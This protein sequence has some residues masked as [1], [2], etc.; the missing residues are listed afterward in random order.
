MRGRVKMTVSVRQARHILDVFRGGDV[1]KDPAATEAIVRS[2]Q[3]AIAYGE[4][5]KSSRAVAP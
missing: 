1:M 3:Q 2:A 4:Q 5:K